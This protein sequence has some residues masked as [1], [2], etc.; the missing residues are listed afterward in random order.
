[1]PEKK[2]YFDVYKFGTYYNPAS[3]H[4]GEPCE[5]GCDRCNKEDIAVCIGW[6]DHDLCLN[7]IAQINDKYENDEL[8]VY[9]EDD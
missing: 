3:L 4:Y 5:V 8:S 2:I 7:C 1:M 9:D 6:G